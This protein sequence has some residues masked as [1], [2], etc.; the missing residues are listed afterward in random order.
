MAP[1]I[2]S[3]CHFLRHWK[4]RQPHQPHQP[5]RQHSD[6]QEVEQDREGQGFSR[7]SASR[8]AAFR[9][10]VDPPA[11]ANFRCFRKCCHCKAIRLGLTQQGVPNSIARSRL[12]IS[13]DEVVK[14]LTANTERKGAFH[15]S[16]FDVLIFTMFKLYQLMFPF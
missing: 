12:F 11:L 1:G 2:S 14:C 6:W 4:P 10:V 5:A 13:P 7:A 9:V 8:C 3:K 16:S 15:E